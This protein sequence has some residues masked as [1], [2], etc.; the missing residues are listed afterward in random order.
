[1]PLS[2]AEPEASAA[3]SGL[4]WTSPAPP[5]AGG[6]PDDVFFVVTGFGPFEGWGLNPSER[7]VRQLYA[8]WQATEGHGHCGVRCC[9]LQT[10][11]K[12]VQQALERIYDDMCEL[13]EAQPPKSPSRGVRTIYV[14]HL[15]VHSAT[16]KFHVE[17]IAH[18]EAHFGCADEAGWR[19]Q[20]QLI[21]N[22]ASAV[23]YR[24]STVDTKALT[25]YLATLGHK[26]RE[27]QDA[28]RF[29]CNWTYYQ[30]IRLASEKTRVLAGSK[31][32]IHTL[33]LHIPSFAIIPENEQSQFLN[34]V[35]R[36]LLHQALQENHGESFGSVDREQMA[37]VL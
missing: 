26:V 13:Y 27:S 14:I 7:L 24:S 36:F 15:G 30:S 1:M 18:N 31:C 9:V 22:S 16:S 8:S 17:S 2:L 21:E 32:K 3:Q 23:P 34:D 4:L 33:F 29:V 20:H 37:A 6:R 25:Q 5:A 10:A 35:M 28:G 12:P 19:P 11:A